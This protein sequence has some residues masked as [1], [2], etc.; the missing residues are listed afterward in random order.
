MTFRKERSGTLGEGHVRI[1][2]HRRATE[3]RKPQMTAGGRVNLFSARR[4]EKGGAKWRRHRKA[5]REK[6]Q[7][8]HVPGQFSQ[9]PMSGERDQ[10]RHPLSALIEAK[11]HDKELMLVR[12][13]GNNAIGGQ[14]ISK[15][16]GKIR[17]KKRGNVHGTEEKVNRGPKRP[18]LSA[19]AAEG[20]QTS[21]GLGPKENR[22][23]RE[24]DFFTQVGEISKTEEIGNHRGQNWNNPASSNAR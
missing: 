24:K 17:S 21:S 6:W 8:K 5:G 3:D 23:R 22:S 1:V 11:T 7:L 12:M 14:P 4:G 16:G 2:M 19:A 9:S 18:L 15:K 10:G 13:G 20:E